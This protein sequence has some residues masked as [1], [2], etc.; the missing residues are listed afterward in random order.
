MSTLDLRRAPK[1]RARRCS[2]CEHTHKTIYVS[3]F[4]KFFQGFNV[5]FILIKNTVQVWIKCKDFRIQAL[6]SQGYRRAGGMKL[7]SPKGRAFSKTPGIRSNYLSILVLFLLPI[8]SIALTYHN[9]QF[10]YLTGSFFPIHSK[11]LVLARIIDLLGHF[12]KIVERMR[13]SHGI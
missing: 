7:P 6:S 2:F 8:C 11:N 10:F 3:I 12:H 13:I 9:G 4:N 5:F 1:R